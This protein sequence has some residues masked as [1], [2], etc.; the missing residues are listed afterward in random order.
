MI[1]KWND[2]CARPE[3][4]VKMRL[5]NR[6]DYYSWQSLVVDKNENV[7]VED[8]LAAHPANWDRLV[9]QA[10]ND[11]E[12]IYRVLSLGGELYSWDWVQ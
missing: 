6:G 11:I 10:Q 3:L 9:E 5:V 8:S 12:A 1:L 4:R 7:Y 2:F